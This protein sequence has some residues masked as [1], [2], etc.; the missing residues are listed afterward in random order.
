LLF[1]YPPNSF[2]ILFDFYEQSWPN[3]RVIECKS[4]DT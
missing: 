1:K 4:F 3:W 2:Q